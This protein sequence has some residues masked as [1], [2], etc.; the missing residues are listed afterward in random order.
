MSKIFHWCNAQEGVKYK[1]GYVRTNH[2]E[3]IAVIIPK[4]YLRINKIWMYD[5][6]DPDL[7]FLDRC[8][9]C[10][11]GLKMILGLCKREQK[12]EQTNF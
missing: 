9:T 7:V 3:C 11:Y 5:S 10:K 2:N 12:H 1:R 8:K 4:D 6:T